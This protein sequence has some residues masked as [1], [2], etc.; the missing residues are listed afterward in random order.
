MTEIFQLS[1]LSLHMASVAGVGRAAVRQ[2]RQLPDGPAGS[3]WP[4]P[5][6]PQRKKHAPE[7]GWHLQGGLWVQ[8]VYVLTDVICAA[9]DGWIA[10][11][12]RFPLSSLLGAFKPAPLLFG[13]GESFSSYGAFL[14]IYAAL[15]L[16]SC[17]WQSL[18]RTLRTRTASEESWAVARA[19]TVATLLLTAFIYLTGVKVLSRF[20]VAAAAALNLVSMIVW[21]LAKRRIVIR[22]V[23]AGIG[24]RNVMIVGAG[25]IG[26][27]L[28]RQFD[29]DKHL[30]Y[31]FKG[32]LDENHVDDPRVLGK[33][34]DLARITRAEFID[35]VF[36]TIPSE[37]EL[38]K[39]VSREARQRRFDVHVVPD[40][41]DG[42]G[43]RAPIHHLG[44]FPVMDLHW[45]AI[46]ALGLAVKRLID[47]FLSLA[48]LLAV[49]PILVLVAVWIKLDSPGPAL[50]LAKRVGQKGRIFTC[51]KFRTMVAEADTLKDSLRGQNERTGAFFKMNDDP[52][53]TRLGRFLRKYSLDE[54]PQLWNA[55][56]GDMSL[57]GPR[58]H[59]L[60]DF[61]QY[62]LDHLRRLEVKPGI[63]GLWQVEARQ[64]PSFETNMHFDL[65]YIDNWN[66]WFDLKLMA[67]TVPVLFKGTGR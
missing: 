7:T 1:R 62:D 22:R 44:D 25:R 8:A 13:A 63:T 14:F 41:Y 49:S 23:E 59:P 56:K 54:L 61:E 42:L 58:P 64:N 65:E 2:T 29:E 48:A 21:R 46:P 34:G 43:W 18:Y 4:E 3:E 47:V 27:A 38:V 15:L 10:F 40:L 37:R 5:R 51:F 55:L 16:L 39:R 67:Q 6:E 36:I 17:Q 53:V 26:Q 20:V 19:V 32:F 12:L 60:D 30:G 45:R 28:A 11:H 57:V 35:E 31:R 50:Y 52:R 24:A 9:A 33:I 66:L